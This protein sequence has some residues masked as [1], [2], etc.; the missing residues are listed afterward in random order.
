M[1]I[2]KS[3]KPQLEQPR[4]TL[5]EPGGKKPWISEWMHALWTF[6]AS[7]WLNTIPRILT[8]HKAAMPLGLEA[9]Y[10]SNRF[11]SSHLSYVPKTKK[12]SRSRTRQLSPRSACNGFGEAKASKN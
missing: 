7:V 2:D 11:L 6:E 3:D 9:G 5:G 1:K 8:L 12:K 4:E 10:Q